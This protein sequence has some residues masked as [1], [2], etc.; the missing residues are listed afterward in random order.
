[1]VVSSDGMLGEWS[2]TL[3]PREREVAQSRSI[4]AHKRGTAVLLIDPVAT[5]R[6]PPP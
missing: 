4:I 1:M 6:F 2:S 3:S 5:R